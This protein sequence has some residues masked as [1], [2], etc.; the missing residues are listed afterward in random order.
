MHI[1][2]SFTIANLIGHFS[3]FFNIYKNYEQIGKL[4]EQPVTRSSYSLASHLVLNSIRLNCLVC[5][6]LSD[7]GNIFVLCSR[8][9]QLSIGIVRE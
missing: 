1:F 2:T 4:S 9:R 7:G 5:P 8:A 3:Y 6:L